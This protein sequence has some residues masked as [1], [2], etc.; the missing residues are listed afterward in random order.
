MD[1]IENNLCLLLDGLALQDSEELCDFSLADQNEA[2]AAKGVTPSTPSDFVPVVK[3]TVTYIVMAVLFN[4]DGEILMMQEAKS[5][6]AG[7]WYLPAGRM[8]PGE[9]IEEAVKRE[10]LEETGLY[11][12]PT[13]L[14]MVQ[15]AS[16]AW[17][18]FILAGHVTGGTLKTPGQADSESLQAKWVKDPEQMSLR[19]KDILSVVE[20]GHQFRLRQE[21]QHPSMLPAV[22]PHHKLLLR[23]VILARQKSSNRVHILLS[24]KTEVHLPICEVNHHHNLHSTIRKFMVEIFGADVPPHKPHGV[25]SVE[26]CGNPEGAHDGLLMTILIAFRVPLEQVFPIDKYTWLMV[27]GGL[28]DKLIQRVPRNMTVP[29]HV[30]S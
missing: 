29:L 19:C 5:S 12:E 11:M 23:F 27:G 13:S 14:I 9:D 30:I 25:L 21:P 8:E 15:C 28:G 1:S 26:H 24:E 4:D 3:N 18:R 6:C 16:K 7:Q 20:R 10:V 2:I 22:R 17:F